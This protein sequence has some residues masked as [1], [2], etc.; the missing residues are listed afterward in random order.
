LAGTVARLLLEELGVTVRG[1]VTAIGGV[2]VRPPE[3][4]EEWNRAAR[5]DL[6]CPREEDEER[7]TDKI[8]ETGDEGDT[9][10]GTFSLSA[11]GLPPGIGSYA[12]W[13]RRLDGLIAGALMSIPAIKGVGI[14]TGFGL[15]SVNGSLAH[16]EILPEGNSGWHRETNNA[17]GIEGGMT[18]GSEI[19]L[20]A[21]MKPIPTLRKPLR[22][23]DIRSGA[24]KKAAFERSDVCAV[25]AA[26]VVGEAMFSWVLA[27]T[28]MEQF[29]GDTIGDLKDRWNS[30]KDRARCFIHG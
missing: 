16:D 9:L 27:R 4:D 24:E 12:E 21:A 17:G 19:L 11:V 23:I 14:G 18:N 5:S 6:G 15:A 25:P 26:C 20:S 29:G 10:G 7:L 13:D 28:V 30:Y 3:N 22:S 8:R 2:E 1:A